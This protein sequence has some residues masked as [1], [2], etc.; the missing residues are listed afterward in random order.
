MMGR[1]QPKMGGSLNSANPNGGFSCSSSMAAKYWYIPPPLI[2]SCVAQGSYVRSS[3]H[4]L[5]MAVYFLC[6]L[7]LSVCQN[8]VS[9][10]PT[11]IVF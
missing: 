5:Q 10:H 8:I 7:H 1:G 2:P 3:L 9:T 11:E 4:N 6:L